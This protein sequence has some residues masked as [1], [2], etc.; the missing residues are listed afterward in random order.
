MADSAMAEL[1]MHVDDEV[2]EEVLNKE[3]RQNIFSA[4]GPRFLLQLVWNLTM[5]FLH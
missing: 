1:E 4:V 3:L 5:L 2:V